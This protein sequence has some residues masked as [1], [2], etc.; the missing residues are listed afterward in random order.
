MEKETQRKTEKRTVK[1]SVGKTSVPKQHVSVKEMTHTFDDKYVTNRTID[2]F[3]NF[4]S[5]L[6]LDN[7]NLLSAGTYEFN[8]ITR[9]RI[10]LE[11]AYRGSW[12]VGAIIDSVAQD[13]TREG[14]QVT[15]TEG[16]QNIKKLKSA[17]SR[18]KIGHSLCSLEKWGRLYG[19]ACGYIELEG[20]DPKTPLNVETVGRGQFQG[21]VPLDR[22]QLNPHM[23]SLIERGADMGLPKYYDIVTDPRATQPSFPTATG[24]ITVHHSRMVRRIGIELPY[25]QAITEMMWGESILERLWDRL[26]T[27]DDASLASANLIGKASLRTISVDRLREIVATGGQALQGLIAQFEMMRSMQSNEG[28]TLLDKED[29]FTQTNYTF[30]GLSDMLLQFYQQLSGAAEIP[31]VRLLGQSPAGLNGG[32]E[33]D[34]RMY[35]DS[36]KAKQEF[37]LRN[38]WDKILKILWRSEF[39]TPSPQDLEFTFVPLWQLDSTEKVTNAKT[40]AETVIGGFE[41]GLTKKAA[42]LKEL[43]QSSGET[44]LFSNI[45]DEDIKDAEEEDEN[46]PMP[47]IGGEEPDKKISKPL[48]SL[49]DSKKKEKGNWAK[50]FQWGREK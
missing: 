5:K 29:V 34:I 41:S 3:D 27:F 14:I 49:G 1:T 13:M 32:A 19:G 9:N 12:I 44:G 25:F 38:P 30:A 8:L 50:M 21:I 2:G 7:D 35:Y 40:I 20:Q 46:P 24:L 47:E 4:I 16:E 17:V 37:G 31:L 36:I 43:R 11:A 45:T 22:W 15:T 6:G 39:G 42:A 28:I 26:I 48:P 18:L 33:D 10:L 23:S